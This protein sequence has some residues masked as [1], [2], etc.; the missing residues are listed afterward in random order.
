MSKKQTMRSQRD[1]LSSTTPTATAMPSMDALTDQFMAAIQAQLGPM[2]RAE[3]ERERSIAPI[4]TAVESLT[5]VVENT[6]ADEVVLAEADDDNWSGPVTLALQDDAPTTDPAESET[7]ETT[8]VEMHYRIHVDFDDMDEES[9]TTVLADEYVQRSIQLLTS[10]GMA[11]INLSGDFDLPSTNPSIKTSYLFAKSMGIREIRVEGIDPILL[12]SDT[13]IEP[14]ESTSS[15]EHLSD[16]SE[17]VRPIDTLHHSTLKLLDSLQ[18][19]DESYRV[20]LDNLAYTVQHYSHCQAAK[21][22]LSDMNVMQFTSIH[23]QVQSIQTDLAAVKTKIDSIL[24]VLSDY[25]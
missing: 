19:L 12:H 15:I 13:V 6:P 21:E 24:D 4:P 14:I 1:T 17:Y 23:E 7:P 18:A 9:A 20:E 11:V 2:I 3:L 8:G 16:S 10:V 5:A 25:H 22:V